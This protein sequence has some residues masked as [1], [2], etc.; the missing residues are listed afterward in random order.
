[1]ICILNALA[2][3]YR[4]G[5]VSFSNFLKPL[6]SCVFGKRRVLWNS[7]F[8]MTFTFLIINQMWLQRKILLSLR[9]FIFNR[10]TLCFYQ[11]TASSVL[12]WEELNLLW[13]RVY[14]LENTWHRDFD[15]LLPY[16]SS[17]GGKPLLTD[18]YPFHV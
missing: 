12:F 9:F 16:L 13:N 15:L 7:T 5:K 18:S 3:Y 11:M 8:S 17:L 6:F 10:Q 4:I 2:W 14:S 1:M